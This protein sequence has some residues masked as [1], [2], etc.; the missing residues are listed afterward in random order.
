M[1]HRTGVGGTEGEEGEE[2]GR[3]WGEGRGRRME[4]DGGEGKEQRKRKRKERPSSLVGNPG[5]GGLAAGHPLPRAGFREA[6]G[7]PTP[8]SAMG[9]PGPGVT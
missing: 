6:P 7:G 9:S 8:G 5:I 3:G 2:N 4:G 1:G